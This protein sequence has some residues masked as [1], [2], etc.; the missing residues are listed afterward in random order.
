MD[1]IAK[2]NYRVIVGLGLTGLSCARYLSAKNQPFAMVDSR[3]QPPGLAEF[4]AE[5]PDVKVTLG[6]IS[7]AALAGANELVVSPGVSLQEPAIAQA[8]AKGVPV[9]G[10]V[11]LFVRE[12]RAPIVAITGSNGKSTVTTLVGEMAKAAGKNVAVG[13]NIGVPVLQLLEQSDVDLYV[14]E[15]SSFQL[16]RAQ[17]LNAEVATVLNL[18]ADHMDRYASMLEYHQAKHRIFF[19]CKKVVVN[20]GDPLSKPI[21]AEGVTALTF[22]YSHPDFKGFGILAEDDGQSYIAYEFKPLLAVGELKIAGKHNIENAMAALALGLSVDLPMDVMLDVLKEFPGL[23]HRCQFVGEAGGVRYYDDSKG[24]NV[25]ASI[26]AINGLADSAE[27]IVLIAGGD[28]KGADFAPLESVVAKQCRAVVL[29]GE[30]ASEI[31]Q[32]LTAAV[33]CV[34][35]ESMSA[36]VA[37]SAQLAA[38]GDAVLLSPACASFDMFNSFEHRGEVFKDAVTT[39]LA[40]GGAV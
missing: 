40:A 8:V 26:A 37:Q 33:T 38:A 10:D 11:D 12:A 7:E 3:Q 25:G 35:A 30:A 29:I 20:R 1:L 21:V 23:P 36:A 18:S 32:T 5:F 19:G 22:G 14:L 39:L 15:L 4:R 31:E 13:G 9:C 16:E 28:G 2:D 6:E 27:K 34:H 24:T 17:P